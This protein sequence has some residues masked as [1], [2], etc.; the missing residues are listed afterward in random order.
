MRR[1]VLWSGGGAGIW[2]RTRSS[3]TCTL[4]RLLVK[5]CV[6]KDDHNLWI[7]TASVIFYCLHGPFFSFASQPSGGILIVHVYMIAQVLSLCI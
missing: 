2:R 7:I 4:L 5:K 1:E 6:E 3:K